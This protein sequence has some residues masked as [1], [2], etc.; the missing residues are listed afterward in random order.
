MVGIRLP[1]DMEN[2][3]QHLADVTGRTKS[4]YVREALIEYLE[5]VEDR[6]LGLYRLENPEKRLSMNDVEKELGLEN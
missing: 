2:R 4:F 6:Y 3:L 1:E 5:D